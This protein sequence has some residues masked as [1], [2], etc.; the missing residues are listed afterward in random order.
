MFNLILC[1]I[2]KYGRYGQKEEERGKKKKKK[3]WGEIRE[4]DKRQL[5]DVKR[6][7]GGK[8]VRRERQ[9]WG[10]KERKYM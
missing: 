10:G 1:P 6:G 9:N 4:I 7:R 2:K 3:K 5:R 8:K